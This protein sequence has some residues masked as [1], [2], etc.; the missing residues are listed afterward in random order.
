[1]LVT[2]PDAPLFGK[3]NGAWFDCISR[4][5][6]DA[7]DLTAYVALLQRPWSPI[8]FGTTDGSGIL[9]RPIPARS[10]YSMRIA[11]WVG[12]KLG[13]EQLLSFHPAD[14]ALRSLGDVGVVLD[15]TRR[16]FVAIIKGE[17]DGVSLSLRPSE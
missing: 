10:E 7:W 2:A 9:L 15:A 5:R 4:E 16:P 6:Y 12:G 1:M 11:P 3:V 13:H 8:A 17:R 14:F